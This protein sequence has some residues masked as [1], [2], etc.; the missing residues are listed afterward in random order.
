MTDNI[1][2]ENTNK[3]TTAIENDVEISE[4]PNKNKNN[5]SQ[6]KNKSRQN[7]RD[8]KNKIEHYE[9]DSKSKDENYYINDYYS[10]EEQKNQ[11]K[12]IDGKEVI[13]I[14]DIIGEEATQPILLTM[15]D[16]NQIENF[17]TGKI[18]TKSFGVIK[19]YAANTNQGIVRDYNED[20]VSIVINMA[21]PKNYNNNIPWPKVSY[22]G[23]FDGH[24]GSKCAEFLRDNLLNYICINDYFPNDIINS[25]KYAF[26]KADEE[27]LKF[28]A[29]Y[30]GSLLDNS[31]SCG[32]ILL[33]VNNFVY[34]GNVGDSRCLGSFKNGKITKDITRDHKP[35]YPYE[36]ERIIENGGTL[37]QTQTPLE[38]DENFKNK[39]LI[40]PYRVFPGKLSVSRTVGDAEGKVTQIGGNPNV[41]VAEP[42]VYSFSLEKDDVDFFILGCDGIY[43]Q[44]SSKDVFKCAWLVLNKNIDIFKNKNNN[45][46][47]NNN[48]NREFKGNYG[49]MINMNTTS[50]NIVDFILKASM[51][52]KSFDNVTCLFI[53]FK[54]FFEIEDNNKKEEIYKK[55][56]EINK[57]E[58]NKNLEIKNSKKNIEND[59]LE[60]DNGN[61]K[62]TFNQNINKENDNIQ[63]INIKNVLTEQQH[64]EQEIS[65]INRKID[66]K[67]R[68]QISPGNKIRIKSVPKQSSNQNKLA[69]TEINTN[70]NYNKT[71][72]NY[73]DLNNN[74][75]NHRS[76]NHINFKTSISHLNIKNN[77]SYNNIINNNNGSKTVF[78]KMKLSGI[79]KTSNLQTPETRALSEA[80]TTRRTNYNKKIRP[81]FIDSSNNDGISNYSMFPKKDKTFFNVNWDNIKFKQTN[82]DFRNMS[83]P[84]NFNEGFNSG[85]NKNLKYMIKQQ[86][87]NGIIK[88]NNNIK[89]NNITKINNN[90][91]VYNTNSNKNNEYNL[92]NL[93]NPLF[94][95]IKK[96]NE[97]RIQK[98]MPTLKKN[99]INFNNI[100]YGKNKGNVK[101]D[102]YDPFGKKRRFISID[103]RKKAINLSDQKQ[104]PQ[105]FSGNFHNLSTKHKNEN[106]GIG[107]KGGRC[108]LKRNGSKS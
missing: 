13:H 37:Y 98:L 46:D 80:D 107:N 83:N 85:N 28:H 18:S 65:S 97:A 104:M 75:T 96:K 70:S 35:N 57:K 38:D 69:E 71:N 95:K 7:S 45:N 60:V 26:K 48:F 44:L 19:S 88:N 68:N 84:N 49:S 6:Q 21:M 66:K 50:G 93:N 102:I 14:N 27:Y 30:E 108:F 25:I 101:P 15:I 86:K 105:L 91:G 47:I 53:A 56:D 41:I 89:F 39:I 4:R 23:I 2:D 72:N 67:P 24:A 94:S 78:T 31:G 61:K 79:N 51:L 32:L 17:N 52:R 20:R 9:I 76:F 29:F 103:S 90:G 100:D 1:N 43:D 42:D 73:N 16:N 99:N 58:N 64:P 5:I 34:I 55:N 63:K 11:P 10:N 82:R 87:N 59:L 40:G 33:I 62:Y 92:A 77:N 8:G 3:N 106:I 74:L 36:K 81:L 22:F 12:I 54:N